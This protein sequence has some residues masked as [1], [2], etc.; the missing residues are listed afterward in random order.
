[1]CKLVLMPHIPDKKSAKAWQFAKTISGPMTQR[2][3]DGFGYAA[4][5]VDD[6][7]FSEKWLFPIDAWTNDLPGEFEGMEKALCGGLDKDVYRSIGLQASKRPPIKALV[8]HAR[9][10]TCGGGVE[11]AHPFVLQDNTGPYAALVHNGVVSKVGMKFEQSTCDSEGILNKL[12]DEHVWEVPENLQT[13]LKDVEGYYALGVLAQTYEDGWICDIIKDNVADL[14]ACYVHELEATVFATSELNVKDA[15]KK[16]KW[17]RPRVAKMRPCTRIRFSVNLGTVLMV[18]KFT[19][20]PRSWREYSGNWHGRGADWEPPEQ[21]D[22]TMYARMRAGLKEA[23]EENKSGSQTVITAISRASTY[24]ACG[25]CG[26]SW[27]TEEAANHCNHP[28]K[29]DNEDPR[30]KEG[31]FLGDHAI[32]QAALA[33]AEAREQ[34]QGATDG[35]TVA[36]FTIDE[37]TGQIMLPD[38][39]IIEPQV[40]PETETQGD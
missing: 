4:V 25:E 26:T 15:C 16:L 10:S 33:R 13:A 27:S 31:T 30:T 14:H 35:S 37:A 38:G 12:R 22:A 1:M 6:R 5:G 23:D 21:D 34:S 19:P 17:R 39:T 11:N 20:T 28:D 3:N 7:L 32:V 40:E 24:H 18:D 9:M 36:E 2:D 8:L 29:A